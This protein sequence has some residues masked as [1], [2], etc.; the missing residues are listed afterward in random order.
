[1]RFDPRKHDRAA[2]IRTGECGPLG[3]SPRKPERAPRKPPD[4]AK[5]PRKRRQAAT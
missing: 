2:F 3:D 5:P 1:M 4:P